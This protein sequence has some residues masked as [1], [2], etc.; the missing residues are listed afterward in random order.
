MVAREL[1]IF[2]IGFQCKFTNLPFLKKNTWIMKYEVKY[3]EWICGESLFKFVSNVMLVRE[4]F[5]F[6]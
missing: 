3:V 6:F 2:L 1:F 5:L 4:I